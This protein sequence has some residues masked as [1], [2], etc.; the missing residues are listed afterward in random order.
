MNDYLSK[1]Y[2]GDYY[3]LTSYSRGRDVW[4][5]WQFDRPEVGE[6]VVQ[7]FRRA[8]CIYEAARLKLRGL[9]PDADYTISDLDASGSLKRSGRELMTRGLRV[10]ISDRPG[11][12][13]IAYKRRGTRKAAGPT[14][15]Q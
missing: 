10:Q 3:P 8:D 15:G 11:S 9:D 7:A 6:G 2:L 1:P 12:A 4:M 14:R 5:A 13:V